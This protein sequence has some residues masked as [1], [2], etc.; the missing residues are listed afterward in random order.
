MRCSSCSPWTRIT[1]CRTAARGGCLS[2]ISRRSL[3]VSAVAERPSAGFS[4]RS[5]PRALAC[6]RPP[7]HAPGACPPRRPWPVVGGRESKSACRWPCSAP[8]W[9]PPRYRAVSLER[10]S[11]NLRLGRLSG[12]VRQRDRPAARRTEPRVRRP[13]ARPQR[14]GLPRLQCPRAGLRL[15]RRRR[16]TAFRQQLGQVEP[17]RG[18][19]RATLDAGEHGLFGSGGI[20]CGVA[21]VA[22]GEPGEGVLRPASHGFFVGAPGN[23]GVAGFLAVTGGLEPRDRRCRGRQAVTRQG[24]HRPASR[25]LPG[26][27]EAGEVGDPAPGDARAQHQFSALPIEADHHR[28]VPARPPGESLVL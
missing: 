10:G 16:A 8:E 27:F 23:L 7:L 15:A 19:I 24:Q 9:G 20:A 4:F 1:S 5:S 3:A 28:E 25:T 22:Q 14:S 26:R 21:T 11:D 18:E 12:A 13:A 2:S 6:A 17:T